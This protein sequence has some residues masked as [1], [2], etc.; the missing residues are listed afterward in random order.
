MWRAG[1]V[2]AVTTAIVRNLEIGATLC[3]EQSV[4]ETLEH[5]RVAN[6]SDLHCRGACYRITP[7]LARER[8]YKNA[9]EASV[10]NS[11]F[12]GMRRRAETEPH[13]RHHHSPAMAGTVLL[14]SAQSRLM[15][16]K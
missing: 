2:A 4:D 6:V 11:S 12:V 13:K 14:P 3:H 1:V 15:P 9:R 7:R 8:T 5:K 16:R 10:I